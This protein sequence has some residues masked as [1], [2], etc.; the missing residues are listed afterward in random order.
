MIVRQA[1][2]VLELLQFFAETRK[3]ATLPDVSEAM[4]WP[5]SSTYNLLT[6][7]AELGFLYEP[8]PRA[9]YYPSTQWITL[10]NRLAEADMLPDALDGV[11][12]ELVEVTGETVAVAAPARL[13]AVFLDV[14]ESPSSIRFAARVGDQVPLHA[15]ASGR[16]ILEQYSAR[17]RATLLNK[18]K[19]EQYAECSLMSAEQVEKQVA[20]GAR[21]GW[22][23]NIEGHDADLTGVAVPLRLADRPLAVV[24]GGPTSRMREKVPEIARTMLAAL[25]Q[26]GFALDAARLSVND[27]AGRT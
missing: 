15:T 23:E 19:Y 5:R 24:V 22:H 8:R 13:N 17:E 12:A 1:A 10:V 27:P 9:G 20:L 25:G 7:L 21:R 14:V 6:T 16:A 4:G 18:V 11:L 2:N 3:P 26:A